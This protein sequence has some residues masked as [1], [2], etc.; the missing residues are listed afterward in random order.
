MFNQYSISIITDGDLEHYD[1]YLLNRIIYKV[2]FLTCTCGIIYTEPIVSA[3]GDISLTVFIEGNIVVEQPT[4]IYSSSSDREFESLTEV[5]TNRHNCE[6]SV[7][8]HIFSRAKI[9]I[10]THNGRVHDCRD[11][12]D[13]SFNEL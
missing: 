13:C 3:N 6:R 10:N 5:L 1:C 2:K 11:N 4:L 9:V 7:V 8:N 12:P